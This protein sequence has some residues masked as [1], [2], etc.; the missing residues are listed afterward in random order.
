MGTSAFTLI[1]DDI[2]V[3][4]LPLFIQLAA[5]TA[6]VYKEI[7][8]LYETDKTGFQSAAARSSYANHA[9][10]TTGG[11]DRQIYAAKYLGI[12]LAAIEAG[13]NSP[14]FKKAITIMTKRW[15]VLYCHI[16]DCETFDLA[17][18]IKPH[19]YSKPVKDSYKHNLLTGAATRYIRS[20]ITLYPSIDLPLQATLK[21]SLFMA[22]AVGRPVIVS[23][24]ELLSVIQTISSALDN[25]REISLL[26]SR[27]NKSA[28]KKM[29]RY[30]K[31]VIYQKI[32][33]N[34]LDPWQDD[35]LLEGFAHCNAYLSAEEGISLLSPTLIAQIKERDVELLCRLYIVKMAAETFRAGQV[36]K[37][38][39]EM[40]LDC[41]EFVML[42]LNLLDFVREYKKAKKYYFEHNAAYLYPEVDNLKKQLSD[43]ELEI[44]RLKTDLTAKNKLLA[45]KEEEINDLAV[46]QEFVL[47]SMFTEKKLPQTSCQPQ[48]NV[49][50]GQV[51]NVRA[52]P[53]GN[54]T[55]IS[56]QLPDSESAI[57][58][59][60]TV[61]ALVIGGADSWQAKLKAKLPHFTYLAGDAA[62]FDEALLL[63]ADIVFANVRCKFSHGCF[64]KMIKLVRQ[65]EKQLVFLS[66]TN[67]P[68]TIRQMAN[69]A[70]PPA[71]D[72]NTLE[73]SAIGCAVEL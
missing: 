69:A 38:K 57:K 19:Y 8:L 33:Q 34:Y 68:L 32:F 36:K 53:A 42:G 39:E 71:P 59:L 52:M 6:S 15:H 3:D 1:I 28:V 50:N 73:Y 72:S 64:Y 31:N 11:I 7:D 30:L 25:T 65:H 56:E 16:R 51:S 70:G 24:P 40:E 66:K 43:Y 22:C 10:F 21:F 9:L 58:L 20:F 2:A 63:H 48:Q 45:A 35:R 61:Q 26:K 62:G 46:K 55:A 60:A 29:A 12:M 47:N 4:T 17:K 37:T 54:L 27:L 23:D 18:V 5:D 44:R 67:I 14:L 49:L 13:Q 41:A